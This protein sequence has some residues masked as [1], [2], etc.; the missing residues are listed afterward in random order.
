MC[1][2]YLLCAGSCKPSICVLH[3]LHVIADPT[4]SE[5]GGVV[6]PSQWEDTE[7]QRQQDYR[8]T[9]RRGNSWYTHKIY[10]PILRECILLF[11]AA[12]FIVHV[13]APGVVVFQ[14]AK[15]ANVYLSI[16]EYQLTLTGG[17]SECHLKVKERGQTENQITRLAECKG[18]FYC[19]EQIQMVPLKWSYCPI[20]LAK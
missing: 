15:H 9:R 18:K 6:Q 10:V 16:T 3:T 14:H 4:A 12:Q 17:N 2:N 8:G 11:L 1:V 13:R 7:N 5:C 20:M 19:F